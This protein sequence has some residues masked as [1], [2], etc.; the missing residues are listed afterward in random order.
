[1]GSMMNKSKGNKQVDQGVIIQQP[2]PIQYAPPYGQVPQ[3]GF[4]RPPM[5]MNQMPM[6]QMSQGYPSAYSNIRPQ[7]AGYPGQLPPSSSYESDAFLSNITGVSPNDIGH[8]RME[9]YNYA[10]QN[11]I[12]DRDGFRKL[13][14]ASLVNKTWDALDHEAEIAF[15]TFDSNGTGGLDFNEYMMACARMIRPSS[16]PAAYPY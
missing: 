12:I 11:G 8:L 4:Q 1:M 6:N 16:Q 2:Q 13:Y 10:N 5:P 9:F 15:R 7:A 3:S 14:I